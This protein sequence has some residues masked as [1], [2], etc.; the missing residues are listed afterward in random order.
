ML[1]AIALIPDGRRDCSRP[2]RV[3]RSVATC[4]DMQAEESQALKPSTH[5]ASKKPAAAGKAKRKPGKG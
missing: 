2:Q 3:V 5:R 4:Q 1:A